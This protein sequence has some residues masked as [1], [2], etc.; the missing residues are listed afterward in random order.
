MPPGE[1]RGNHGSAEGIGFLQEVTE[2]TSRKRGGDDDQMQKTACAEHFMREKSRFRRRQWQNARPDVLPS[3]LPSGIWQFRAESAQE[4]GSRP[5]RASGIRRACHH[6]LRTDPP[7][8]VR[9]QRRW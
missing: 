5:G 6:E 3:E 9:D 7:Q 1:G 4:R 2:R 8:A